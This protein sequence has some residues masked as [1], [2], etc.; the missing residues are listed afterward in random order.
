LNKFAKKIDKVCP[1]QK[2][3]CTEKH[4]GHIH[5][6]CRQILWMLVVMPLV[7]VEVII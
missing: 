1:Y 6:Q 7:D 3:F 4:A 2:M 5:L